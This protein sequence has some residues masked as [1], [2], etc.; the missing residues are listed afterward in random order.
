[1]ADIKVN[2]WSCGEDFSYETSKEIIDEY[3][4]YDEFMSEHPFIC[5]E[6]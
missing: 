5:G 6:C 2:C 3:K 1:M 4:D